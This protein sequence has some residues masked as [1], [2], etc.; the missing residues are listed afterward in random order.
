MQSDLNEIDLEGLSTEDRIAVST[1]RSVLI[2]QRT[3]KALQEEKEKEQK[4]Q[5]R[6]KAW[7]DWFSYYF[8]RFRTSIETWWYDGKTDHQ[9]RIEQMMRKA[10]QA[11][12]DDPVLPS[13]EIRKARALLVLEEAVELCESLGYALYLN[14]ADVVPISEDMIMGQGTWYRIKPVRL[15]FSPL[16]P[17]S[18]TGIAKEA[19]DVSVVTIGTLSACG[20]D[21][22]ALLKAV[23]DNNLAKF[24]PGGYLDE[25]GKWQKPPGHKKP[26]LE[27]VLSTQGYS[28]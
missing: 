17:D 1:A 5:E 8:R 18:L 12:P 13:K 4:K 2:A 23:D 11:V 20:I 24:G 26:D 10:G 25:N 22:R 15:T 14:M 7:N 6:S 16:P 27:R 3:R 9:Y 21:D 28:Q 19:A